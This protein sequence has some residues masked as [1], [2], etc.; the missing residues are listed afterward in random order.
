MNFIMFELQHL[1]GLLS[2]S[3]TVVLRVGVALCGMRCFPIQGSLSHIS[4]F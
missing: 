1:I 3:T 2:N 4:S